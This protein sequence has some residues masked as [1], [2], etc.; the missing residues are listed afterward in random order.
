M[1]DTWRN[2][3]TNA[4]LRGELQKR[5]Q[6]SSINCSCSPIARTRKFQNQ[7]T[8]VAMRWQE[9]HLP[10]RGRKNY[11]HNGVRILLKHNHKGFSK[12]K[13]QVQTSP[14]WYTANRI[15]ENAIYLCCNRNEVTDTCLH[16]DGT[17]N[18]CIH[19][20]VHVA[21]LKESQAKWRSQ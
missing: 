10:R 20:G 16:K 17:I 3:H 1:S 12:K 19:I 6:L 14:S 8:E 4:V 2:K 11:L 15:S 9:E 18:P 7:M 13:G 21:T 5:I